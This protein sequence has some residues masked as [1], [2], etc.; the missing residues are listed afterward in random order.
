MSMFPVI[1]F[2]AIATLSACVGFAL[3]ELVV[4]VLT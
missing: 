3:G 1:R 4:R 2:V